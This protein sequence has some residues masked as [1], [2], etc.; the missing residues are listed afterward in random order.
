M[1][2]FKISN[3][4]KTVNK[5]SI[6]DANPEVMGGLARIKELEISP[7]FFIQFINSSLLIS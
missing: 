4:A 3:V 2:I 6:A 7:K 1:D 5:D